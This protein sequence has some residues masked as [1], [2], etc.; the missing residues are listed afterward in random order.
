[1]LASDAAAAWL[2]WGLLGGAGVG[3]LLMLLAAWGNLTF[4]NAIAR[5]HAAGLGTH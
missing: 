4:P 2:Q 3:A 5:M 1:M